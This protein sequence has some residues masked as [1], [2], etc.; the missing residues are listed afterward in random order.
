[1]VQGTNLDL[2]MSRIGIVDCVTKT[3]GGAVVDNENIKC[4]Q[5]CGPDGIGVK[6]SQFLRNSYEEEYQKIQ[7]HINSLSTILMYSTSR[8]FSGSFMFLQVASS[9]SALGS[10]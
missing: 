1:M 10:M 7:L 8:P 5:S 3:L 4:Q 2:P 9:G 6:I